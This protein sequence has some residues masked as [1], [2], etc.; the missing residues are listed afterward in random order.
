M[1]KTILCPVCN[2]IIGKLDAKGEM[3]KVYLWCRRCRK[4]IYIEN[5]KDLKKQARELNQ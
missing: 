5:A 2:K 3:C 4:E 1:K